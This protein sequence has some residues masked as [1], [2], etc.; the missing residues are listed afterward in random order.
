VGDH[1]EKSEYRRPT[2]GELAE[3]PSKGADGS[4]PKCG[5]RCWRTVNTYLV[6]DGSRQRTQ[7]CHGCNRV[8]YTVERETPAS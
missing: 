6:A 4:C 1:V 5:C 7:R 2:L 8:R 3:N